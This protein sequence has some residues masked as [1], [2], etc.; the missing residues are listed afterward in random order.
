MLAVDSIE[1]WRSD[2][3]GDT[4]EKHYHVEP[5]YVFD[6]DESPET[7]SGDDVARADQ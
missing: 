5:G 1:H 6:E 2:S 4:E 3:I 7:E